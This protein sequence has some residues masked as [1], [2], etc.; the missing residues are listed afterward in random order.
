LLVDDEPQLLL[1][2]EKHLK[3][4]GFAVQ[5]QSTA[6]GALG[7]LQAAPGDFDLVVA[8]HGLPDLPGDALLARIFEI[9]PDLP[10]LICSGSEFFVSSLPARFR[11]RVAFLQK[12]FLPKE[13]VAVIEQLLAR[14][15]H[16]PPAKE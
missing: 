5:S 16:K 1:L 7:V 11:P 10:V 9:R 12:P 14:A 8:D 6:L 4:L 15:S 13:L 3:R 2:L